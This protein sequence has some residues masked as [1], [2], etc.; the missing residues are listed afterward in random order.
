MRW[1]KLTKRSRA[2]AALTLLAW[3]GVWSGNARASETEHPSLVLDYQRDAGAEGC[4]DESR[5][6]DEVEARLGYAP[7]TSQASTRIVVRVVRVGAG[8]KATVQRRSNGS[9][10]GERTLESS[11]SECRELAPALILAVTIAI[12]PRAFVRAAPAPPAKEPL[13]PPAAHQ[14]VA[15]TVVTVEAK[16]PPRVVVPEVKAPLTWF[17]FVGAAVSY[18]ALPGTA[19]GPAASVGVRRRALSLEAGAEA[20]LVS[21]TVTNPNGPGQADATLWRLSV[22]PCTRAKAFLLCALPSVGVMF[23]RG[24]GLDVPRSASTPWGALGVRAGLELNAG[25]LLLVRVAADVQGIV[26]PT[27]LYVDRTSVWASPPL[28]AGLHV[29]LGMQTR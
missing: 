19:F 15:P 6:R 14:T 25:A 11:D 16:P 9:V 3:L 26:T 4:P 18:G 10:T 1:A 8:L 7:F 27:S 29:S 13:P 23:G 21:A 5:F 12:D 22:V 28:T 24:V 2:F 17:G 20:D